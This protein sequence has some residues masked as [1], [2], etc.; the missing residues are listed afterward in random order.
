MGDAVK[1]VDPGDVLK[2]FAF[3]GRLNEDFK[4]S[5]GTWVRVGPLRMRLLAH[6]GG[7]L[8]DVVL[9]GPDRD[10]VTALFFPSL[11]GC[12]T[13]CA[14]LPNNAQAAEIVGRPEVRSLFQERLDAF[15]ALNRQNSTCIMRA[16][17]LEK[18][19]SMETRELTDK[20]S[21]NQSVMLKNRAAIVDEL[22]K[23]PA[24]AQILMIREEKSWA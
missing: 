6:F 5:S 18:P 7:L 20:G 4:L 3:D 17:L 11:D 23:D 2:G 16:V 10:Y 22:Y 13:G 19:P 14:G 21:I 9:A 12:K 15:A 1:F 24:P 8:Q